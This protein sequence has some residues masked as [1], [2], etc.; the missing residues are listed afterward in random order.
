MK[1][2]WL[3]ALVAGCLA[4][5]AGRGGDLHDEVRE[6][7]SVRGVEVARERGLPLGQARH[8]LLQRGD[9]LFG[10]LRR[11]RGVHVDALALELLAQ[12]ALGLALS[13]H[14]VAQRARG[15]DD[16]PTRARGE[17]QP[18]PLAADGAHRAATA[19]SF[20]VDVRRI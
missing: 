1:R 10:T 14:G 11:D 13:L 3:V 18:R 15:I 17:R 9:D 5:R 7:G 8:L 12:E 19:V 16:P 4:P 6:G 2:A 20:C